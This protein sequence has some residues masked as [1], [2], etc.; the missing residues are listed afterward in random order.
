M[1]NRSVFVLLPDGVGLR[2]FAYGQFPQ[3]AAEEG[4]DI[5][6][7]NNTPFDLTS[8]GFKEIRIQNARPRPLTDLL[9]RARSIIDL[10]RNIAFSDDKVYDSYR[11]KSANTGFKNKVKTLIVNYFAKKYDSDKG[12]IRLRRKIKSS[13][14]KS[15]YY[16]Q[17]LET[18]KRAK[19]DVVF[20]TNQRPLTAIS[21]ILAAQDLGIPTVAFIFSWDNVP[22]ATMVIEADH[23]M[24]W[25]EHMK[26]ELLHY[27]PY[28]PAENIIVTGTPQFES[29]FDAALIESRESFFA[30]HGLD[31]A[32]KY[33]CYSGDDITTSPNDPQYLSDVADAVRQLNDDGQNLG[34]IFR[35]CPVDFSD[36]FDAVLEANKD[37]IVPIAPA[38]KKMGAVWNAVL[39][40][41]EDMA[42]QFNTIAH[43]EMVA[44]LGSSM[45][46]DYAAHGKPCAFMNYNVAGQR[47]NWSV[48]K[49]YDY[50]H[51]RSMPDKKAVVWLNDPKEIATKIKSVLEDQEEQVSN[52]AEWFK[53]INHHPVTEASRR[54]I[55][56]IKM[57]L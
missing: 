50:V 21:P 36:R 55:D 8:L 49:I 39:P 27:Y 15:A 16:T 38:W 51:F 7:W 31:V 41:R 29:H 3:M 37:L 1:S 40:M 52:A 6:F 22:K 18:L 54:I 46:F 44:N 26:W 11:M 42:L 56:G 43:T 13:E 20:C 12:L 25:S 10:N 14:R 53:V 5:T 24:V 4:F 19:P 9:K 33:I 47:E 28:I 2:N 17:C 34:I 57:L 48:E 35:R 23:Y 30:S 32:K 45:V